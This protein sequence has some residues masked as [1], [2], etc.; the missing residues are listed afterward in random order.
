MIL[1]SDF[2]YGRTDGRASRTSSFLNVRIIKLLLLPRSP[3]ICRVRPTKWRDTKRWATW[4]GEPHCTE[5]PARP[6]PP[7]AFLF[8]LCLLITFPPAASSRRPSP[9][10]AAAADPL[11]SLR[12]SF[13]VRISCALPLSPSLSLPP[14][15]SLSSSQSGSLAF[16][17][18]VYKWRKFPLH[19]ISRPISSPPFF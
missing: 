19:C 6:R 17:V 2:S 7:Q 14:S 9:S 5:P 15:L 13:A 18:L 12:T 10:P 8:F 4:Q 11:F 1:A 16:Y 3:A